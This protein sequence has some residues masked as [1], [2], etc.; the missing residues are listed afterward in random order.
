MRS[1]PVGFSVWHKL[2][3]KREGV[4][5]EEESKMKDK[6]IQI[7]ENE[8]IEIVEEHEDEMEM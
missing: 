6:I 2:D 3:E 8:V 5:G 1:K 7:V 4:C